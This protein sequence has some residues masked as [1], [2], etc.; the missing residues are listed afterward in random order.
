MTNIQNKK[1]IIF[2]AIVAVI[3][4]GIIWYIFTFVYSVYGNRIQE[5]VVGGKVFRAE[6]VSSAEK[7][8]KGL[9]GRSGLCNS[10]AMLFQFSNSGKYSFW[11]KDMQF[12]L[13]ILW[14]NNGK[15][16]HIEKKVSENFT[17]IL[18]SPE[19]ADRVLE[20][21]VGLADSYGI[22]IGDMVRMVSNL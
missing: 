9:G 16:V 1:N 15:I 4:I 3:I 17:G 5:M 20:I 11:M 18:S 10:C 19:K 12:P 22:K 6:I 14:I 13:D 8:E 7:M 2:L 21:N